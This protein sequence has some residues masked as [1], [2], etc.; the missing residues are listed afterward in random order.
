MKVYGRT[1]VHEFL[2]DFVVY[3]NLIPLDKRL[4]TL[5]D[6]RGS[7]TQA[8]GVPEGVTPRKSEPAYARVI[9][10]LLRAART[11]DAPQAAL[12]R[13]IYVGDTRMNDGTAFA[14]IA[15]AGGWPGM[16]FIAS[17]R[18]D[19]Q[20]PEIIGIDSIPEQE[21]GSGSPGTIYLANRWAAITEGATG[22]SFEALCRKRGFPIDEQ[23]AIIVD[24]DKTAL[25]ARG[26][27][28]HVINQARV[29]AVRRTVGELLGD[30]FDEDAFQAAYDALNQSEFH[31][32]TAD[33][34]DYLAYICLILGSGLYRLKPLLERVRGWSRRG[35]CSASSTRDRMAS[36][37]QFIAE[38]DE[39]SDVLP[40][41]LREIHERIHRRVQMGDPTPF[42]AFRYNEYHAT[43]ERM[44]CLGDDAPAEELLAS[45]IVITQEVREAALRW[46]GQGALLFGLSDK[47]DEASVPTEELADKGFRAIHRIETHAVGEA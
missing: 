12:E 24:L 20:P 44:G 19:P 8:A 35:R 25:G 22:H 40:G 47:P 38:V 14:N 41:S 42:K 39:Q 7:A 32:F 1:S 4:P 3:R 46:K 30:A 15:R 16:A 26:R 27:N 34:Q 33:N 11:I 6:V 37:E 31:P 2:G 13:L 9:V 28:D 43:V 36:F 45:E 17:E 5:D 10:Q 18:S 21:E 29:E 23:T